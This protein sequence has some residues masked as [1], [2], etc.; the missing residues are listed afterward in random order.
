MHLDEPHETVKKV[1]ETT[2]NVVSNFLKGIIIKSH[3]VVLSDS[4]TISTF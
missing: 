2:N 3:P 4:N 1:I